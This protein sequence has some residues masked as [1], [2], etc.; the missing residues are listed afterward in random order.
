[1]HDHTHNPDP[2]NVE[3]SKAR[4]LAKQVAVEN[5]VL[6]PA[7]VL[8]EVNAHISGAAQGGIGMPNLV[9]KLMSRARNAAYAPPPNPQSRAAIVIPDDYAI[10]QPTVNTGRVKG[11]KI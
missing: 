11:V 2:V 7:Q 8:G 3:V 1:M 10:F 9:K 5:P 6:Q 4:T